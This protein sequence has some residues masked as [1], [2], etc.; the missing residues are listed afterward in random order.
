MLQITEKEIKKRLAFDNPWWESGEIDEERRGW[1]HR[2]YFQ[3]FLRLVQQTEVNRAVVLMGPRRVGK[4]VMLTQA[5]QKLIEDE[6]DPNRIFYV[7]IDTPTYTGVPLERLLRWFMEVHGHD[8]SDRLFVL[9][10]EIQYHPD[11]ERH[12]KS[13][14]DSFPAMRFIASGSAAAALKM[15]SVESGAGRFTDFLLPPLN[16]AEYL[17]FVGQ[18]KRLIDYDENR[19]DV[20]GLNEAF[21]NYINFGGFPE[22]VLDPV[23]RSEMS[24]FVANDIIDKVLLRDLPSLYGIADTQEL[25]RFFTVLAYNTGMEVSLE[26]L[27]QASGVAKNTLRKYLDYLEAAFLIRRLNRLD[28][29]AKKFK[30]TTHFKVYLT[31]PSIRS[32]LFGPVSS[33]DDSMGPLVETAVFSQFAQTAWA[34]NFFYARWK[35]GEVDFIFI[36]GR[37]ARPS[38]AVEIKWSDRPVKEP[39]KELRALLQFCLRVGLKEAHIYTRTSSSEI[40]IDGVTLKFSFVSGFCYGAAVWGVDEALRDGLDPRTFQPLLIDT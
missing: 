14:V 31:N 37:T 22:A 24:R 40:S 25:K 19:C 32:A 33:N 15:K 17:R 26:G 38:G 28:R 16:F 29:N 10:D 23:V 8:R 5:I 34:E 1:P 13:L 4:T 2:A 7:S 6:I 30:R 11:W 36:D 27:A 18:E 39:R 9:F 21:L 12:L 3:G 20:D 35:D